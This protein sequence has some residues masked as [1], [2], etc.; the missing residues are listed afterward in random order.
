MQVH[1]LSKGNVDRRVLGL[2]EEIKLFL[3]IQNKQDLLS[4]YTE[5][6]WELRLAYVVDIFGQFNSLNVEFQGKE[7]LI[8]DFVRKL[9]NCRRKISL[10]TLQYHKL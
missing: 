6:N 1:W 7:S 9:E 5:D 2:R 3:G 10:V 4:A 8:I